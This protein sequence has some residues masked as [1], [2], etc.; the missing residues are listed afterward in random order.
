MAIDG[1]IGLQILSEEFDILL[2][3][4][5]RESEITYDAISKSLKKDIAR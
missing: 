1:Q 3:E 2:T 5:Q 4:N